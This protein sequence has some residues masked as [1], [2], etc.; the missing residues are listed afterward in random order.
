M[1]KRFIIEGEWSGYTSS[2]QRV[3]H[4]TV[5]STAFKRLRAW[6]EKAH[7][8]HYT[9][10]TALFLRV[11]DCKPRE[12][13]QQIHG[14]DS[15]IQD[16]YFYNVVSVDALAAAKNARKADA[17]LNAARQESSKPDGEV[18]IET[19]PAPAALYVWLVPSEHMIDQPGSWRIRKWD[20]GPF[21][22][23]THVAALNNGVSNLSDS[24]GA[25]TVGGQ[26]GSSSIV[27]AVA[28]DAAHT[29]HPHRA[30]RSG[31]NADGGKLP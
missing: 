22:E 29:D 30:Q 2:Q 4:R 8:I 6:A 1:T 5:H 25:R 23:A 7:A 13:V 12:R 20:T 27:P 28:P 11:R 18:W 26:E 21:P 10:G 14:Y 17:A 31:A 15:L 3:V 9:N 16:C 19:R 24:R